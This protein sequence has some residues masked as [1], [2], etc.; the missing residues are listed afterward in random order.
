MAEREQQKPVASRLGT[1]SGQVMTLIVLFL[2]GIVAMVGWA[3]LTDQPLAAKPAELPITFERKLY[4]SADLD[5]A[6]R[7]TD[8]RGAIVAQFGAGEAVFISTISRVIDR[9]RQKKSADPDAPIYLRR[10]GETRLTIFDPETLRETELS[11]FGK[12][13]VA[14]FNVLLERHSN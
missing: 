10:R 8:E 6:A 13:N 4:I 2:C 1:R 11:S 3:R 9:E 7:I 14:S 5:G 12:D